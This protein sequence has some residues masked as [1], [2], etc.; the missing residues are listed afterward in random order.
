MKLLAVLFVCSFVVS[1]QP[2]PQ[3]VTAWRNVG[4]QAEN[5]LRTIHYAQAVETA[6]RALQMARKFGNDDPRIGSSYY[7]LAVINRDWGHCADSRANYHAALANWRRQAEPDAAHMF[8][9]ASGLVSVL[10]ECDDY[11]AA[12]KAFKTYRVELERVANDPFDR[13]QVLS[14]RGTLA[15]GRKDYARAATLFEQAIA[16]MEGTPGMSEA[17]TMVLHN[18]LSVAYSRMGRSA[19]ALRESMRVVQFFDKAEYLHASKVAALNNAACALAELGRGREAQSMFERAINEGMRL[20]G[21]DNHIVAKIMLSYARVLKE[22]H[23]SPAAAVWSKRGVEAYQRSL[24]RS[25]QT[26]DV[27]ELGRK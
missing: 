16:I 26:V 4:I 18:S 6:K 23:E 3:A 20:Y 9:A 24:L 19:D 8:L 5:E 15:R 2:T 14:L 25:S 10:S 27:H 21:E 13:A 11:P 22:N 7:L 1:A 17:E 12:E